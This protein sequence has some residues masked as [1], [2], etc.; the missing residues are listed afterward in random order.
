MR[1]IDKTKCFV[2]LKS[3]S[4]SAQCKGFEF[5]W[6]LWCAVRT[7]LCESTGGGWTWR[8][9]GHVTALMLTDVVSR[10]A[11]GLEMLRS[12]FCRGQK[13]TAC[14]PITAYGIIRIWTPTT[15][16]LT[17][18][19]VLHVVVVDLPC[20]PV[21]FDEVVLGAAQIDLTVL[22]VNKQTSRQTNKQGSW[23]VSGYSKMYSMNLY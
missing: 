10:F 14:F 17:F 18:Y 12:D 13:R 11:R 9:R 1:T 19:K 4:N 16:T 7:I 6:F 23:W 2:Y 3:S 5:V 21:A 8:R 22:R 20:A 15:P